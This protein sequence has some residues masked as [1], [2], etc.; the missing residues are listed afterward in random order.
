MA[1]RPQ[2]PAYNMEK[3]VQLAGDR[4]FLRTFLQT[5]APVSFLLVILFAVIFGVL[6]PLLE[7]SHMAEKR[8]LCRNLILVQL[9]YLEALHREELAGKI[10]PGEAKARALTRIRS[11]RFGE[12]EKDYFWI[13]GPERTL[14]MH[15]YRPDLEGANPDT[16]AGPDGVLLRRLFDRIETAVSSPER[17]GIVDYQWQFKDDLNT[18]APKTSCVA[19]FEPWNWIV[20]TGV[21]IDDAKKSMAAWKM[22]FVAAGLLSIAAAGAVSLFLSLRA[23]LL[24]RKAAHAALLDRSLKEKT[25]ELA[26]SENQ[27][28]LITQI[29]RNAAEGI[30]ITD[31]EGRILEVNRAFTAITG[32]GPEEIIGKTPDMLKSDKHGPDFYRKM[33]DALRKDGQ[34]SGEIWDR[35]KNGEAFPSRLNIFAYA[36][37]EGKVSRYIGVYQD[38]TELHQSRHLLLHEV[39]HDGL[40]GLPNRFLFHD[41][42][43]LAFSRAR[44]KQQ[45]LSVIMIGLDRF[46]SV[47]KTLGYPVG[48]GLLQEVGKRLAG[49]AAEPG[50]VARFGGDEFVVL[51]TGG[52]SYSSSLRTVER[53]FAVLRNPFSVGGHSY[54]ITASAGVTFYPRDG[55]TPEELLQNASL[56]MERAKREGGNTWRLFTE[57]LDRKIQR[58]MR[59]ESDLR[60]GFDAGEF[61]LFYQ[62]K[63]SLG[64]RKTVGLEALL[65]WTSAD[66]T[67]IPPDIFIPLAEEIGEIRALGAFALE[68]VCLRWVEWAARKMEIPV[69]VNISA[70]QISSESFVTDVLEIVERTGM[71][72]YFLQLEITESAFM[73]NPDHAREVMAKLGE[74]GIRFSLDDFGTGFSSLSQLRMLPIS[75]LKIDRSFML[76]MENEKTRGVVSTMIHLAANLRMEVTFEGVETM[77]QLKKLRRLIP[78]GM[79]ASIQGYIFSRPLPP[80]RIPQFVVSE[81][82]DVF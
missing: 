7:E 6:L 63:I 60:R 32:Y 21:Y 49:A 20:G 41:R 67:M 72:P 28:A 47:N 73:E 58:R 2:A 5:M 35:R 30:M 16:T 31:T 17:R 66:G 12:M 55:E 37:G 64:E 82:P 19:L 75:E 1:E 11:L 56:S 34:W 74:K 3:V 54:R 25:L 76:D 50:A 51:L 13:L 38:L 15:P 68:Q 57:D 62:P 43:S 24:G 81:L 79:A 69:A 9:H 40:T 39:N 48:D 23:V 52:D 42:L 10:P 45:I 22:R 53:M 61:H 77:E 46:G 70:K 65:R 78:E 44:E 14:L 80:E 33:W 8:D 71:N 29:Y 59:L 26:R 4:V 36:G 18:L 27:L